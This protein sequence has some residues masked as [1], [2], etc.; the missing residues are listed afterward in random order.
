MKD[1]EILAIFKESILK[2]H[3]LSHLDS[4]LWSWQVWTMGC[5]FGTKDKRCSI[6]LKV[7]LYEVCDDYIYIMLLFNLL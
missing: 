3:W 1:S 2:E 7:G 6:V 5:G 4:Y